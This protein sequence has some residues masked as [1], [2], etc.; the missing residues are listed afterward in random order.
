[1]IRWS[2]CSTGPLD[3]HLGRGAPGQRDVHGEDPQRVLCMLF[4]LEEFLEGKICIEHKM[5]C[6]CCSIQPPMAVVHRGTESPKD[7]GGPVYGI[8]AQQ[9]FV[10]THKQAM[11]LGSTSCISRVTCPTMCSV[12]APVDL[13]LRGPRRP[14]PSEETTGAGLPTGSLHSLL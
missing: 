3:H 12:F 6:G 1:M 8:T 9:D 11:N 7:P 13:V 4:Q 2:S 5:N 10:P 14:P